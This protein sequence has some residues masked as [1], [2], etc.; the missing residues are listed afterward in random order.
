MTSIIFII[1]GLIAGK[2]LAHAVLDWKRE[3]KQ[4]AVH[5]RCCEAVDVEF[6][7]NEEERIKFFADCNQAIKDNNTAGIKMYQLWLD[8]EKAAA[9]ACEGKQSFIDL[10]AASQMPR[11]VDE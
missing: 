1:L 4:K 7:S 5:R 11:S 10:D 2:L 8:T 3:Q 9:N 6:F